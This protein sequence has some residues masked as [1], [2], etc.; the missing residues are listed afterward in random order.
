MTR[1]RPLAARL[2]TA[3]ALRTRGLSVEKIVLFPFGK[4]QPVYKLDA[5]RKTESGDII[6]MRQYNVF[7]HPFQWSFTW[8]T[9]SNRVDPSFEKW[10]E[11]AVL[12]LV[13]L[14]MRHRARN[15]DDV[16]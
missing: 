14:Q 16:P 15:L 7:R 5:T 2:A 1:P 11:K 9:L 12:R 4:R 6:F 10:I 13:P 8:T 3:N